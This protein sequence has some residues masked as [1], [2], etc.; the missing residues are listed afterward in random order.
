VVTCFG[1]KLCPWQYIR[2]LYLL[3]RLDINLLLLILGY[4]DSSGDKSKRSVVEIKGR[5][6]VTSENVDLAK[7]SELGGYTI[8]LNI[9]LY[10]N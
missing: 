2:C 7:V 1:T 6:S 8:E 3:C 4:V 5:F 10:L 9:T